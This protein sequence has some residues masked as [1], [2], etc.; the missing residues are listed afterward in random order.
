MLRALRLTTAT[1]LAAAAVA[2]SGGGSGSGS[3][4]LVI[5]SGRSENLVGSLIADFEKT[6]VDVEVRYAG[7]SELAAQI[8]EEGANRKAD[9]F[10]SQDAGALGAL[11]KAGRLAALP[12]AS[13]DRVDAKYRAANGTWVGVSGRA[14]VLVYNPEKVPATELPTSV[15]ELT[16]PKWKG[17]V[18]IAPTNASFQSF[19]TAL[20]V[21]AGEAKARE[22]LAGL[23]A[24]SPQILENNVQI[25]D[26]VDAGQLDLGLVNHYY[27]YEKIAEVGAGKVKARN[28]FLSGGDAGALVNVAGVGVLK[29]TAHGDAAQKFVDFLLSPQAQ[30]YFADKTAEYPLTP[31]A[32]PRPDLPPLASIKGPD[33][34]LADLDT[35]EATQAMLESVGLI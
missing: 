19:V 9:V 35:L 14:R 12:Q 33:I 10:F 16:A 1:V 30:K 8:L 32:Q 21:S 6:G 25:R 3:A 31:D 2:C 34:D 11:A 28:H 26:A 23:Q 5:Y 22:W 20:R 18:G 7:T 17:R 27:L 29:G 15:F 4:D 13:L 24:N